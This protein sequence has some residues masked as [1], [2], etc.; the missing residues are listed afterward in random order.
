MADGSRIEWTDATW[1]PVKGCTRVSPGCGGPGKAGGC[2]AEIMAARFSKPGQ[3]G[4]G[5]AEI[6][7]LP[8]GS[9]RIIAGPAWCGSTRP[10][11]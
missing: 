1:T 6:V 8:D 4:E 9:A 3:W 7:T 11:C 5:L 2:Y 10:S